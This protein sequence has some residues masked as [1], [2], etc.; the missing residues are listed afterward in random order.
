MGVRARL[1]SCVATFSCEIISVCTNNERMFAEK[2]ILS[3]AAIQNDLERFGKAWTNK[4]FVEIQME[5]SN[6][7]FD[8]F[9]KYRARI[10]RE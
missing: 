1:R 7:K 2:T 6:R 9:L 10:F 4:F 5:F 8:L 3:K